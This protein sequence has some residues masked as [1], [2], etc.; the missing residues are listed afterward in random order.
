MSNKSWF[1]A[2][3]CN[4]EDSY[5]GSIGWNLY[6]HRIGPVYQLEHKLGCGPMPVYESK[7]KTSSKLSFLGVGTFG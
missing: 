4:I 3:I 6:G 5:A 1:W 7:S 2:I